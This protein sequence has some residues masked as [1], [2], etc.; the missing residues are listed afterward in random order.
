[1]SLWQFS[2]VMLLGQFSPGPDMLLLLRNA[3]AHP[4]RVGLMTVL[5]IACGLVLHTAA[6][7]AGLAVLFARVPAAARG[8]SIAGGLYLGWLAWRL[9]RS[10]VQPAGDVAAEDDVRKQETVSPGQAWLQGFLTNLLNPKAVIFLAGVLSAFLTPET[11][12][13]TRAACWGI[14]VGQA[15]VF[16][17]LFVWLLH[18]G[19]VRAFYVRAERWLNVL[20]G[21]ALAAVAVQALVTGL[22]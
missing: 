12:F 11:S 13:A 18:R 1:M 5:G 21:L 3:T 10:A 17:S 22:G 9:L 15:L 8:L 19:P 16:W 2:L 6:A 14:V 4:M 20:F 7:L